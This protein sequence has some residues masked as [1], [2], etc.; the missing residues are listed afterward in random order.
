M[1]FPEKGFYYHYKHDP[2]DQATYNYFYEVVGVALHT[3]LKTYLVLYRP[4]YENDWFKTQ[5]FQARPIE[6]FMNEV[7]KDG[8]TV[9]RFT[10]VTDPETI[11]ELEKIRDRMYN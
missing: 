9:S 11:T 10:K 5:L 7:Q 3:E 6:I 4:L 8:K 1:N 2:K